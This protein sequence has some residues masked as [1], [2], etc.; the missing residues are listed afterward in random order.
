MSWCHRNNRWTSGIQE[1]A[2]SAWKVRQSSSISWGS[3]IFQVW[4]VESHRRWELISIKTKV[5]SDNGEC[6]NVHK[7]RFPPYLTLMYYTLSGMK[8]IK[9]WPLNF[10][11]ENLSGVIFV[12][13]RIRFEQKKTLAFG[14]VKTSRAKSHF[15]SFVYKSMFS[16]NRDLRIHSYSWIFT[17]SIMIRKIWGAKDSHLHGRF[18]SKSNHV[19]YSY[20]MGWTKSSDCFFD[21]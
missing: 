8:G 6:R 13:N 9:T 20:W 16:F 15:R 10:S 19:W 17:E 18:V 14:N 1:F 5:I 21:L 3:S 11:R 7:G 2:W 4:P 12:V